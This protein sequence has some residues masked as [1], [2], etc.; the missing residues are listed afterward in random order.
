MLMLNKEGNASHLPICT[1]FTHRPVNNLVINSCIILSVSG[2]GA[3]N[4][5]PAA[6]TATSTDNDCQHFFGHLAI[7]EEAFLIEQVLDALGLNLFIYC[8]G[9]GIVDRL[10]R[11]K[12]LL[13]C[14]LKGECKKGATHSPEAQLSHQ[15]EQHLLTLPPIF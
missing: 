3:R 15:A 8:G 11:K 5:I 9:N 14:L 2:S 6:I 1:H 12:L 13:S 10:M 7:K 4:G